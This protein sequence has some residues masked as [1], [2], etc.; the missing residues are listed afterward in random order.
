MPAITEII[1]LMR[2]FA[3]E[4]MAEAWDN[5]GLLV[6]DE[7]LSVSN[8]IVALDCT[9]DCIAQAIQKKAELIIT[10]H[11]VIFKPV[12]KVN[13]S[14]ATGRKI[15]NLIK[16]GIAVYC[17]HTNLD[18]TENGTNDTLF[19]LLRLNDRETLIVENT[20]IG[21]AGYTD[22]EYT[23]RDFT[24][25]TAQTLKSGTA[26]FVGE[27]GH[28]VNKIG[29]C[30]GAAS[31]AKYMDAAAAS[32]CDV[33]LTGDVSYHQAQYAAE[34]GL[35]LVIAPHFSTE[36]LITEIL[37]RY[38]TKEAAA[39]SLDVNFFVQENQKDIFN[40]ISREV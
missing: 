34:L 10:H 14:S 31:G 13:T 40:Y 15:I 2:N 21:R 38:L 4:D 19:N 22:K 26:C 33:Y 36:A 32:G 7:D 25:F 39:L 35:N 3:S 17:S 30:T 28:I 18:I 29:L 9:E 8:V 24:E 1:S 16:N 11:P 20:T 5:T 23:L 6:G 37:V 27:E 12:K